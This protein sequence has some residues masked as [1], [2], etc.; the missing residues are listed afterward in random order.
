[1]PRAD[2]GR[3]GLT[4]IAAKR[5]P[6]G[7]RRRVAFF[8][9]FTDRLNRE[10]A[11]RKIEARRIPHDY[12]VGCS[13][14]ARE[15]VFD[16][17]TGDPTDRVIGY[18]RALLHRAH[19]VEDFSNAIDL[20]RYRENVRDARTLDRRL[21]QPFAKKYHRPL[22]WIIRKHRRFIADDAFEETWIALIEVA[23]GD[24]EQVGTITSFRKR[25]RQPSARLHDPDIAIYECAQGVIDNA[26][27]AFGEG[28]DRAHAFDA[29]CQSAKDRQTAFADQLGGCCDSFFERNV[30]AVELRARLDQ[31]SL[32]ACN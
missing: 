18:R 19:S 23:P 4:L 32:E 2:R 20:A 3:R 25:R 15:E 8:D 29:C 5:K 27:A 30:F 17:R 31:R 26:T 10:I 28:H 22:R 14:V 16:G 11:T 7:A 21:V 13:L 9:E 1:M 24:D 6:R 12:A